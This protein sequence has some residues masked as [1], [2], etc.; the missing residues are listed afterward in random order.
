[1]IINFFIL[2]S[3][4]MVVLFILNLINQSFLS[5]IIYNFI[6]SIIL[7]LFL[8]M[9][10]LSSFSFIF[11]INIFFAFLF[12]GLSHSV[13]LKMLE[14]ISKNNNVDFEKIRSEVVIP[15]FEYR[16]D[17]LIKKKIINV[18]DDS[19]KEKQIYLNHKKLYLINFLILIRELLNIK[20]YG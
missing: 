2:F 20:N 1:M 8:E 5:N 3:L 9:D 17:N 13:S 15:S 14:L 18:N 7:I 16:Y 12:S 19:E 11:F 10:F 6:F 4:T